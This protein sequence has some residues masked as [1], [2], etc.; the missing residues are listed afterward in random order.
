[1]ELEVAP[2]S[3]R[4]DLTREID[5]IEEVARIHGYEQIPEDVAV[6]MT[7]SHRSDA[8]RLVSKVR[9]LVTA[10]GFDEAMTISAVSDEL[11]EAF[12][13]WSSSEPLRCSVPV[14]KGADCLRRSL[15]PSLLGCRAANEALGNLDAELF[16]IAKIYLP[17]S[18]SLPDELW[19]LALVS[20]RDFF[21]L[22]GVVQSLLDYLQCDLP[23][24]AVAQPQPLFHGQPA[25]ELRLGGEVLGYLGEVAPAEGKRLGLRQRC[26]VAELRLARLQSQAQLIPQYRPLVTFPAIEQ[27]LN[28]I[29]REQVRWSELEQAVRESAGELLEQVA[30]RETYRDP[31]S[32][33][34]DTKRMLFSIT[35]RGATGTLTTEE[36]N[37]VRQ[38]VVAALAS[39]LGGRLLG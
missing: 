1:V 9:A 3:W 19:A 35:L 26:S 13:P 15:V 6:P 30:Y 20:G 23:L 28:V 36:A 25:A 14:I 21:G 4:R 8:E 39:Q 18:Q 2:P 5:A 16:E 27:D 7:P 34:P 10:T 37:T 22:K 31:A 38:R 29:V 32:D 11:S 17:R 33:G 24:A 12:S